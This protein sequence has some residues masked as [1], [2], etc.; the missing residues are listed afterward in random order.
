[1]REVD[2]KA[3]AE[4]KKIMLENGLITLAE[5]HPGDPDGYMQEIGKDVER[6]HRLGL[7]HPMEKSVS[8][9]VLSPSGDGAGAQKSQSEKENEKENQDEE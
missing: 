6:Y 4:A 7:I 5:L 3:T 2:I 1:M 8:G 9:G